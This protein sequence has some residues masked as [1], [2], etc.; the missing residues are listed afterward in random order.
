M[1]YLEDAFSNNVTVHGLPEPIREFPF[2]LRHGRKWRFDFAW[3][4]QKI[5]VEIQG[6]TW[7]KGAHSSGVGLKRDFEKNNY[8]MLDGWRLFYFDANMVTSGEAIN[9]M[10][11]VFTHDSRQGG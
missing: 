7:K 11:Q 9:F 10:C 6:A 4:E 1:S 2:A 3:L 8:A 5:A